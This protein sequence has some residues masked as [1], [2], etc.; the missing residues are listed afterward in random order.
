[1][2]TQGSFSMKDSQAVKGIA[3]LL[4]LFHHLFNDLEE[5]A[6][7]TVSCAP[8][9][10]AHLTSLA[11]LAKVCVAMFVFITGY[12]IAASYEKNFGD[13]EPSGREMTAFVWKR[14]IKVM[15]AYWAVFL[16]TLLCQPLGRTIFDA[17]G[18]SLRDIIAGLFLDAFGLAFFVQA[19][20]LNPAWWYMSLAIALVILLPFAVRLMKKTRSFLVMGL[21][22]AFLMACRLSYD[23]TYYFFS[24]L[25]GAVCF[26]EN[27][28]GRLDKRMAKGRYAAVILTCLLFAVTFY[29]RIGW[30]DYGIL[31]GLIAFSV[32]LLTHEVIARI[33]GVN[34]V[35]ELLGRHSGNMYLFHNQLYAYYFLGFFYSFRHWA[36]VVA[37][38]AAVS[39][40]VSA[41]LEW[42]KKKSGYQAVMAR[43]ANRFD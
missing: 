11:I 40:A 39:L 43:L 37:A 6:G 35:L 38:L 18:H 20:T 1:M 42:I 21:V 32:I 23:M 29:L 34:R 4:M 17:Y 33:P 26:E 7:Y 5:Y 22:M 41:A 3:I 9:S 13:H 12:G 2:K 15:G 24:A 25:L 31:E 28:F 10:Q 8:F 16:L 14:A 36:L 19:P 27:L 30:N